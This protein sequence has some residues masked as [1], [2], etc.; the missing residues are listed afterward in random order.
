M[1]IAEGKGQK[2]GSLFCPLIF[3]SAGARARQPLANLNLIE[4]GFITPAS[5]TE[6]AP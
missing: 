2:P 5:I 6:R 4:A 1:L 3:T